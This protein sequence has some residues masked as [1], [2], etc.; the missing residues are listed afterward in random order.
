[1]KEVQ[2]P[3]GVRRSRLWRPQ[4]LRDRTEEN[5]TSTWLELFFDLCFVVAVAALARGLHDDPTLAG[6]L[7][8]LGL[9]VPVWWAWM[10]FTWYATAFDNDDV[11]YRVT[12]L[13]AMLCILWLAASVESVAAGDSTGFV[14]AYAGLRLLLVGLF[15]RAR[16]YAS[17]VRRFCTVYVVGNSL[18]A[19]LWL[20]SLLLPEPVRYFAWAAALAVELLTPILAVQALPDPKMSFHPE[21]IP[22][23]YGLFTLIVLGESVLA[24]AAGTAGTGWEPAAVFTGVFGFVAA[25]CIWWIYFNY[26]ESRGLE[27]G[28]RAAFNWGY[29]HL[30][31][32]AGIAAFGVGVEL[33]IEGA[34][35]EVVAA[36][37]S[38]PIGGEEFGLGARAIL[39]GGAAL[40]LVAISYIHWVNEGTLEDR[41]VP[42]R[43]GEAAVFVCLALV[44]SA[45]SPPFFAASIALL[46]VALTTFET[47]WGEP[48]SG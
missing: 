2:R 45:L 6:A 41:I 17:T 46:L 36:A 14:L 48:A 3:G 24:V 12:M 23:R 20:G 43:L 33:A 44:G 31:V 27:L 25:A 42:V 35:S 7:R 26:V 37:P 4:V 22:E 40:Y 13:A 10:G 47:V 34:A 15:V 8:F 16:R 29:G 21:H 19:I 11:L 39:G 38:G 18:G 5:R 1:V 32:Y 9:F 30:L 28:P